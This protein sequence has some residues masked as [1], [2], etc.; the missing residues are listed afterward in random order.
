MDQ[1]K[2]LNAYLNTTAGALH[3]Y[4]TANLQ[5]RAQLKVQE[6][7]IAELTN[8]IATL[9]SQLD[10]A[11]AE[12]TRIIEEARAAKEA[13]ASA[14]PTDW[15]SM[16]EFAMSKAA[17]VDTFTNQIKDMKH[18]LQEKDAY[19]VAMDEKQKQALTEKDVEISRLTQ[20]LTIAKTPVEPAPARKRRRKV[21]DQVVV[22]TPRSDDDF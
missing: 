21:Q 6:D 10:R 19:I 11:N 13:Q 1:T 22:V 17:H 20:E 15:K 12:A 3:E 9:Q 7:M 16:Y 8:Y 5:I 14:D 18:A 2:Y 4:V